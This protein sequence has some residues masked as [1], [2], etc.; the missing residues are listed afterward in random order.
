MMVGCSH[1]LCIGLT[2]L[3]SHII[4]FQSIEIGPQA[5]IKCLPACHEKL[6]LPYL[7]DLSFPIDELDFR[8]AWN[9]V[10]LVCVVMSTE[11]ALYFLSSHDAG[12]L[13]AKA[14]WVGALQD[15]DIVAQALQYNTVE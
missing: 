5:I 15:A 7:R 4:A 14:V 2:L 10:R 12:T 9:K 6:D 1:I 8:V 13:L 3:Q 11:E